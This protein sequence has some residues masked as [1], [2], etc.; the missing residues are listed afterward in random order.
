V[1]TIEG[2]E[3]IVRAPFIEVGEAGFVPEGDEIP[4]AGVDSREAI[5]ATGKVA[6]LTEVSR[7][8]YRQDGVS[9][10]LSDELKRAMIVKADTAL[11]SQAAPT[12]P[13]ITPAGLL[14]QDHT[15]G[16]EITNDLDPVTDAIA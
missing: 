15:E 5:I 9:T 12:A 16:G 8:Q 14:V 4:D 3:P 6:I 13:A 1:A 2:D 10:L 11:L 7:E